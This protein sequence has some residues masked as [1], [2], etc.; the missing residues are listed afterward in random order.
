MI[1]VTG[2]NGL[3]G[4]AIIRQLLRKNQVVRALKRSNSNI[5]SLQDVQAQIDWIDGD[6]L[7]VLSLENAMKGVSQVIHTAAMVFF[8]PKERR[9]MYRVNVEGTANIVNVCM[10]SGVKKIAFISSIASLGRP[11]VLATD[12]QKTIHINEEQKWE[13]SPLNSHYAKSKYQAELEVWRGVAEGLPAVIINPSIVLGEGDWTR[14]SS[15]LF[16]Y[17]Y[18]KNRFYTEGLVNYVDVLDVA[19]VTVELLLSNIENERFV[20]NSGSTTYKDLFEKIAH[21]FNQKP[22]SIRI[23]PFMSEIIW[24]IEAIRSFFTGKNPLITRE[25]AKSARTR[26]VYD[27]DKIKTHL[28]FS[29]KPLSET[30]QRV[31]TYQVISKV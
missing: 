29:F 2:A 16:K 3:V 25:T 5:S 7:D 11:D 19:T 9:Q 12:S 10:A 22:P 28:R 14:S 31:T 24:R 13:D 21:G 4:S 6:L 20:L 8:S 27:S 23:S 1:L 30:I 26:F 18:D 15:Q 17:V